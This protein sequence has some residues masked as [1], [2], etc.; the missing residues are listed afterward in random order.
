[1]FGTVSL[2]LFLHA[3]MKSCASQALTA[4]HGRAIQ[5]TTVIYKFLGWYTCRNRITVWLIFKV[6]SH[7]YRSVAGCSVSLP[8]P[9]NPFPNNDLCDKN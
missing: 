2:Y 4:I 3:F 9:P 6:I 1:M 7:S 5:C 8:P